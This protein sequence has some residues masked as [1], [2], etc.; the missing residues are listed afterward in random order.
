MGQTFIE[1][2]IWD[3]LTLSHIHIWDKLTQSLTS[4]INLHRVTHMGQTD[5]ESHI[6]DKLTQSQTYG[7]NLH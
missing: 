5:T 6:W 1:S 4:W 3:K 7:I 2:L